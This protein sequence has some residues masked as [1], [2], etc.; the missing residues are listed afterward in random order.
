MSNKKEYAE[1][2][3]DAIGLIRDDFIADSEC[4]TVKK[5]Y[6]PKKLL[7]ALA[8]CFALVLC[9]SIFVNI[10]RDDA[11]EE[12]PSDGGVSLYTV[13]DEAK[14]DA[15]TD[16]ELFGKE[17]LV[18]YK[19]GEYREKNLTSAQYKQLT[20]YMEKGFEKTEKKEDETYL[21]WICDGEGNVVSP[22]LETSDG[23]VYVELFSYRAEVIPSEEFIKYVQKLLI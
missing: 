8:A 22:Y 15:K 1:K 2:L 21:V 10:F 9:L 7:T 3:Y 4:H 6:F 13:L 5:A 18:W 16:I 12:T 19:D 14:I 17:K 23:N 20:S 11:V